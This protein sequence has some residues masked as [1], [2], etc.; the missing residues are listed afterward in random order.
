VGRSPARTAAHTVQVYVSQLR[1]ALASGSRSGASVIVTQGR[2]Y[3]LRVETGEIDLDRFERATSEARLTLS[4]GDPQRAANQLHDAL[5]LFRGPPLSDLAHEDFAQQEIAR[6]EDLRLSAIEDRVQADLELGHHG[7]LVGELQTLVA[8]NPLRERLRAHLMIALYRSGR[9]AEALHCYQQGRRT[10]AEEL[11][12]DPMPELQALQEAILHQDPSLDL[13]VRVPAAGT[14]GAPTTA[15][16]SPSHLVSEVSRSMRKFATALFADLVS[17][18]ELAESEDPEV[19]RSLV[20]RAFERIVREIERYGGLTEKFVGDAVLAVF[21][22]PATHEAHAE[23]RAVIKPIPLRPAVPAGFTLDDCTIDRSTG[24]VTCPQGH[25]VPISRRGNAS[26]GPRCR[27]C[28]LRQRC[29]RSQDGRTL[30]VHRHHELLQAARC[31]AR[32]EAFQ[33]DYRRHRPMVERSLAWLVARGH[34]R[35][36]YRGVARNQLGLA[37]RVA[38]INL[39]R[40][41]NMGLDHQGGWVLAL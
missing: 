14:L 2:G 13:V 30:R 35:L 28:P 24:T 36:R 15:Q 39:R 38:A 5:S 26:F 32:T 4:G 18:T 33:A 9:Q 37:H 8:A 3:V 6:I 10:L 25:T 12:I 7:D 17:S 40:L 34:R 20:D 31:Q 21:G 11:G 23:H 22:I 27:G 29:T 19:V 16:P 41:V 1:K